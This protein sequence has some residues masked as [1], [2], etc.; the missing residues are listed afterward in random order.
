MVQVHD[1]SIEIVGPVGA[2]RASCVPIWGKH[3]VIDNKLAS[4][5]K[6]LRQS[7]FSIR[8]LKNVLF[9]DRLPRQLAPLLAQ[10][11]AQPRE[12]L[13]FGKEFSSCSEP[14]L[15]RNH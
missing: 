3:E 7:L 5:V 4:S 12:F 2:V 13:L 9:C 11:V 14:L 10:L 15:V 6:K 1:D 8:S